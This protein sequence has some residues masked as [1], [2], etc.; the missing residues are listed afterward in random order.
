MLLDAGEVATKIARYYVKTMRDRET[1]GAA[2]AK[3]KFERLVG[4]RTG[5]E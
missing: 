4:K 3:G 5:G 1:V 2:F